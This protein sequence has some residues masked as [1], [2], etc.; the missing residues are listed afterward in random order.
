MVGGVKGMV[1][2]ACVFEKRAKTK[3][4]TL[5]GPF[6]C[7]VAVKAMNDGEGAFRAVVPYSGI[8]TGPLTEFRRQEKTIPESS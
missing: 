8:E 2:S 7:R 5:P 4:F 1:H 3:G 6:L